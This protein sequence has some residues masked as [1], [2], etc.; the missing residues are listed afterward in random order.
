[1]TGIFGTVILGSIAACAAAT[2]LIFILA[3]GKG[4]Y[5]TFKKK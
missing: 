1:M 2:A 4:I 5:D 3:A